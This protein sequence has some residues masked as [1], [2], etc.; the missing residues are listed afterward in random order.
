MQYISICR[1]EEVIIP[2]SKATDNVV[3]IVLLFPAESYMVMDKLMTL[4][5]RNK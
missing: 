1:I 2:T 3:A 4:L 5:T